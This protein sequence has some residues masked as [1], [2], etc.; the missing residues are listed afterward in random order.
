MANMRLLLTGIVRAY[1]ANFPVTEGKKHVFRWA[2]DHIAPDQTVVSFR[3]KHGFDLTVNLRNPE[4]QRMYFYGEHDERYEVANIQRILRPGDVCWD[5]GAN[6]G[7]YTCLFASLVGASGRVIAF[8]PAS[9]TA[10][11]LR[12]NIALNR[13]ET[14]VRVINKAVGHVVD[15]RKLF[16]KIADV[17]EG[18]A[19]LKSEQ[20]A[21]EVVQIDTLDHMA[22]TLPPADFVKIDVE[23]YQLEVLNGGRAY[24][25]QHSPIIMAELRDTNPE[26]MRRAQD[27]L[28]E[29]GY[30]FYEFRK[31]SITPC[32]DIVRSKKRNFLMIKDGSP[33]C[34]RLGMSG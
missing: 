31:H 14:R 12:K 30:S 25:S 4:H 16:F 28:R 19:S 18:T 17:A 29:M 7:F 1:L 11:Y 20:G 22:A 10:E 33:Y 34:H 15:Q 27:Y 13:F 3:T 32:A 9:A 2:K 6:I 5:I 8:E 23:G 26:T 24:F 21:S